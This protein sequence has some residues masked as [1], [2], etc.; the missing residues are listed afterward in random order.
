MRIVY[1]YSVASIIFLF[2][3]ISFGDAAVD[4]VAFVFVCMQ[5]LMKSS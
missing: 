2:V 4:V 3:C 1:S 5:I